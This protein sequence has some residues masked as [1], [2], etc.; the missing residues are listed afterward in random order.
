M[1]ETLTVK[2]PV[3]RGL[4]RFKS[5]AVTKAASQTFDAGTIIIVAA[6]LA[7]NFAGGASA[8]GLCVAGTDASN[9]EAPSGSPNEAL[10]DC[11][12]LDDVVAEMNLVGVLAAADVGAEFGLSASNSQV[13]VL[14]SDTTNKRVRV[15]S[16]LEGAVGDTNARV[17]VRFLPASIL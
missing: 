12:L 14:K 2:R 16:I 13:A 15:L 4:T 17:L 5:A 10:V 9:A 11:Y 1:A 3:L 8:V 6:G 7:S